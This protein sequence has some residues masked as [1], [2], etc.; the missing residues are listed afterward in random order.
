MEAWGTGVSQQFYILVVGCVFPVAAAFDSLPLELHHIQMPR[1][2][3]FVVIL[4]AG[5]LRL[6]LLLS[7]D[8]QP[9]N[10]RMGIC[11]K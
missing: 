8:F 1:L 5:K 2:E 6:V 10:A 4:I 3:R 9:E 11:T 7:L